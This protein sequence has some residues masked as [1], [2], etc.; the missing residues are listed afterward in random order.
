MSVATTAPSPALPA[1]PVR[2]R[3]NLLFPGNVWDAPLFP[4]ALAVTAGIVAD[5]YISLPLP[6]SF[7]LAVAGLAAWAFAARPQ[8]NALPLV[9]LAVSAAALGAAHHHWQR[10]NHSGKWK[11]VGIPPFDSSPTNVCNLARSESMARALMPP[12]EETTKCR[13]QPG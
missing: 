11:H 9:Y 13:P 1:P 10:D 5:R 8:R 6:L 4:V 3:A 2:A 12:V 7:V